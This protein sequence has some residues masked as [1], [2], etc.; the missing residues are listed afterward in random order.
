MRK[1]WTR[2]LCAVW[3]G[4]LIG[5]TGELEAVSWDP[6]DAEG[7]RETIELPPG[8][9]G[10]EPREAVIAFAE[11][12]G[13]FIDAVNHGLSATSGANSSPTVEGELAVVEGALATGTNA[14]LKISCP[15]EDTGAPV[16][17]FSRGYI[18]IDSSSLTAPDPGRGLPTMNLD[19]H[20]LLR[21]VDCDLSTVIFSGD[22]PFF[23]DSEEESFVVHMALSAA[24]GDI[25]SSVDIDVLLD[26][27]G[28]A[29]AFFDD[30]GESVSVR[31][32]ETED[33]FLLEV[34]GTNGSHGCLVGISGIEC[35]GPDGES[36]TLGG[37]SG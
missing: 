20:G 25:T 26:A 2:V 14:Y 1:E 27:S 28:I 15:G 8:I 36:L 37:S 23:L 22:C 21:F 7:V 30:V 35:S 4:L 3:M 32:S 16:V 34:I 10:P 19:G 6:V 9:V 13:Q 33:G 11:T 17:D 18:R 24:A 31:Y 12:L 5:C 29:F